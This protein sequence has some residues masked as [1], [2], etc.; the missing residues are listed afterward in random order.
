M[1]KWKYF[2]WSDPNMGWGVGPARIYIEAESAE[3]AKDKLIA[4]FKFKHDPHFIDGDVREVE[5]FI[6]PQQIPVIT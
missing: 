6:Q 3:E 4:R 2:H 5:D 1:K